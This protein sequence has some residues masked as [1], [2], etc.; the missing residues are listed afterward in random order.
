MADQDEMKEA[1]Y[2]SLEANGTIREIK[3]R[4]RGSIFNAVDDPTV[5]MPEQ[6][7]DV[8][9][10]SQLILEFMKS[11][12]SKSSKDVFSGEAGQVL[13]SQVRTLMANELG[14]RLQD[15][16]GSVPLLVLLVQHLRLQRK[17]NEEAS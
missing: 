14:F 8:Y 16:D 11:M 9:L 1:I 10:A 7:Q 5:E 12:K 3:A 17:E 2:S 6:P 4:L 13:T 15:D